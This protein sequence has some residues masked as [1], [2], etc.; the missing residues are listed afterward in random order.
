MNQTSD[1]LREACRASRA[2]WV[3]WLVRRAEQWELKA[4]YALSKRRQKTLLEYLKEHQNAVWLNGALGSRRTRWRSTGSFADR[5]GTKRLYA[6]P[7]WNRTGVVLVGAESLE[8]PAE[9]L[10]RL[11]TGPGS[12]IASESLL[13]TGEAGSPEAGNLRTG[14]P[15][16]PP[17][18][19]LETPYD[20]QNALQ[21][22]LEYLAA[23]VACDCA[24]LAIRYGEVFRVQAAWKCPAAVQ[25]FDIPVQ[26]DAPLEEI[27]ALRQGILRADLQSESRFAL[28]ALLDPD[29]R[30]WMGAP[31]LVGQR[32]IGV[33][34]F[35]SKQQEV[36]GAEELQQT[37]QRVER[38]AYNVEN[39]IIFS[40]VARYL[41]QLA[42][43]NELASTAS[44]GV[45]KDEF[46]R[47]VMQRLRRT[48]KTDWAAVL[49]L[50]ADGKTLIEFGG[51]FRSSAGWNIPVDSSL[52]GLAV[53]S[54]LPIRSGDVRNDPRHYPLH[55]DV[56]SELAVPLKYRGRVIG[57]LVLI[58]NENNAFSQQD[59][60]LLVVIASHMAGLFENARLNEE[61]RERAEK[62]ADSV[63]QLQAVRD[64]SLD[65]AGDLDLDT[66]L[67]RLTQRARNLVGAR[68]AELGLYSEAEQVVEIVVSDTPWE[69]VQGIRIPL[70]AGVAGRLAAFG[71]PIVVEDYNNWPGRLLPQRQVDF[72]AV[73]GV[74]LKFKG[75]VIG[76]LTV[77]D[78]RPG[79]VF[80]SEDVQLLELLA[81]QAAI[82]IRNARLYQELQERIRAQQ[83]AEARLIR[84]ARLAAVGEMAAGVAHELNNP[85]TTVTGFV[86]LVLNELPP[87]SPQRADLELVLEEAHRA[88]GVVRRLLDFTRPVED[89]R[90]R[91]DVNEL[92][93]QVIPLV[94]HLA[95]TSNVTILTELEPGLP[96][97]SLDPNQMKQVL[98]NLIHNG[99][100]AMSGGGTLTIRT[101]L[102]RREW[103]GRQQTM[104][105][106][107]ISDTGEG[108]SQEN[109]DRIFEPFF[110]TRPA[111]KGTGLGLSV[112]YGIV[113]SHGGF[114][115]VDSQLGK[116]SCFTVNLPAESEENHV[117]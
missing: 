79:K 91:A 74:P 66:L 55:P 32:V 83:L 13:P 54:G 68:G 117:P 71:E 110:T 21:A 98:L 44:L 17:E 5:L 2:N 45:D 81:P 99:L 6:F 72:H 29:S 16:W 27:L 69:N 96:W 103:A 42:L 115:E 18:A 51:G 89:Q 88:R 20:P 109:L 59:E 104:L 14:M 47:R 31:I 64:T 63:R 116:G 60:Q 1:Q 9:G 28:K 92:I 62:L 4:Q 93:G 106:I 25:G 50:S 36:F 24:Y 85:L 113:S 100:Q 7:I 80:R 23:S 112:S 111:G 94:Q 58:S 67:T 57:A 95:R 102:A 101:F 53:Q 46:A 105:S 19:V 87:D 38:L 41:Q 108:I 22:I 97:I 73:A 48:F 10:Y 75:Q 76:T 82:S 70:M 86:E 114:I 56:R 61:T 37:T 40:E 43:L 26:E 107:A 15:F 52:M 39:A 77:L 35:V 11:I 12:T 65:I 8:K 49:L 90:V 30:A 33:V 3:A 34:A 84:S 78:D